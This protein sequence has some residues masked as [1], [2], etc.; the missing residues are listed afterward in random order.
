MYRWFELADY[1]GPL[2]RRLITQLAEKKIPVDL[3]L[4]TNE[5]IYN[6]DRVEDLVPPIETEDMVPEVLKV[7]LPQLKASATG[8]TA[9]DFTRAR[10]VLPKVLRFARMLHEAGVP[11]MIGTDA[12][13]GTFYAREL[14]LHREAGI[15]TW[16]V[17]RMATSETADIMGMGGRIGR[18]AKGY[19]ADLVVLEGDPV[20]DIT[21]AARVYGVVNNGH[22]LRSVDL[23]SARTSERGSH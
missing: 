1:D 6:I 19:E 15:A 10:A 14:A 22:W 16:D 5:L 8:W 9:E 21:A 3:T 11:M 17:L 2:I 4:T 18:I 23:R 13:G 20:A 12:G 7:Y